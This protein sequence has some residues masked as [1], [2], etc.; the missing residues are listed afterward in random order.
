[1]ILLGIVGWK[2]K[3]FKTHIVLLLLLLGP[4]LHVVIYESYRHVGKRIYIEIRANE[5]EDVSKSIQIS[6]KPEVT[7]EQNEL[8]KKNGYLFIHFYYP[9]KTT[10]PIKMPGQLHEVV[11]IP[12]ITKIETPVC[13]LTQS[14]NEYALS[15]RGFL[16]QDDKILYPWN[17]AAIFPYIN[18][19]LLNSN[20]VST[21]NVRSTID[22][23]KS[24]DPGN[25]YYSISVLLY[26]KCM[27]ESF[28]YNQLESVPLHIINKTD[29]VS[30]KE[31][32]KK[33]EEEFANLE[34]EF[35]YSI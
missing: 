21:P 30:N 2:T 3:V 9:I 18:I 17:N 5:L 32:K 23:Q 22:F 20:Q 31:L 34:S 10:S 12:E 4:I 8:M 24:L 29:W 16:S 6:G 13:L 7:I 1:M 14:I 28:D 35:F 27:S 15:T 11:G 26:G 19:N 25:Y 33:L